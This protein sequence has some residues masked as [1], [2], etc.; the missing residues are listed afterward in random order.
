M[1]GGA[2]SGEARGERTSRD[3]VADSFSPDRP[4]SRPSLL[5]PSLALTAG[6]MDIRTGELGG[7]TMVG[8]G[9]PAAL[10]TEGSRPS[11]L[12]L[13]RCAG[14][15]GT[16]MA[17]DFGPER[18]TGER[19]RV[20]GDGLGEGGAG[21]AAGG[22]SIL[23]AGVSAAPIELS[24]LGL[25]CHA[26][27]EFGRREVGATAASTRQ[28]ARG[29]SG[30]VLGGACYAESWVLARRESTRCRGDRA[31]ARRICRVRR[32]QPGLPPPGGMAL[33]SLARKMVAFCPR[34]WITFGGNCTEPWV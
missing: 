6:M 3:E 4:A 5:P 23:V 22:P 16:R 25:T 2:R 15:A 17:G 21:E 18:M 10:T 29:V 1:E 11:V 8:D 33:A 27:S 13:M 14:A 28:G 9:G 31:T 20:G 24:M 12:L 32:G 34:V 19:G 26:R 7:E 30:G